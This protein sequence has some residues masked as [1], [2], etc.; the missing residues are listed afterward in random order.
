MTTCVH[1]SNSVMLLLSK[2]K[3]GKKAFHP[4]HL[5]GVSEQNNMAHF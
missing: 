5:F 1:A 2:K 3:R 4:D